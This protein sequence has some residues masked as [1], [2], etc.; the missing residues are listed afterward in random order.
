MQA[1]TNAGN[2]STV[3]HTPVIKRQISR[4]SW[5]TALSLNPG[6][7]RHTPYRSV[8]G[9]LIYPRWPLRPKVDIPVCDAWPV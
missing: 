1:T 8:D 6:K 3:S 4:S 9:E 7:G 5:V 2:T